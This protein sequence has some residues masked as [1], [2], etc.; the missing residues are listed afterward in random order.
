MNH[1]LSNHMSNLETKI[2]RLQI[3][4]WEKNHSTITF[5]S[6][7]SD[8]RV[9]CT[10]PPDEASIISKSACINTHLNVIKFGVK[11]HKWIGSGK[12]WWWNKKQMNSLTIKNYV[13][14]GLGKQI[15]I[16]YNKHS[17]TVLTFWRSAHWL[18]TV[19]WAWPFPCIL[20]LECQLPGSWLLEV[21]SG[22]SAPVLPSPTEATKKNKK[23]YKL[24]IC[25]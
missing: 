7:T 17:Y 4:N 15:F 1:T 19:A 10:G 18:Q 3:S 13:S 9:W 5:A 6:L 8:L 16:L 25:K 23:N 21:S 11:Q 20:W 22:V 12:R 24:F 14:S 2:K